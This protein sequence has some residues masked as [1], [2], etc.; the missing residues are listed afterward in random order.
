MY[1]M[2]LISCDCDPPSTTNRSTNRK[3]ILN[4]IYGSLEKDYESESVTCHV[5]SRLNNNVRH[6]NSV[7]ISGHPVPPKP[8]A[9]LI[10]QIKDINGNV[11]DIRQVVFILP[12]IPIPFL[13]G[14][15]T[16]RALH[17]DI[18]LEEQIGCH[19]STSRFRGYVY[20]V[21]TWARTKR[22]ESTSHVHGSNT[23]KNERER[24]HTTRKTLYN[25]IRF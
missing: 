13:L 25:V 24:E 22:N 20:T 16:Q 10:E 23:G 5:A 15:Q 18:G 9:P 4:R 2:L 11:H 12:S 7:L 3:L 1:R 17:F 21:A 6:V 19:C 8:L 14:L